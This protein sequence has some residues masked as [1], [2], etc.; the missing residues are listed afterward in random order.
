M[1]DPATLIVALS[2]IHSH[3]LTHRTQTQ[4]RNGD[5][6]RELCQWISLCGFSQI[7]QITAFDARLR[8]DSQLCHPAQREA[9][10]SVNVETEGIDTKDLIETLVGPTQPKGRDDD[11]KDGIPKLDDCQMQ[12][13][14]AIGSKQSSEGLKQNV[15]D[16]LRVGSFSRKFLSLIAHES[17]TPFVVLALFCADGDNTR[18]ALQLADL[19]ASF[20]DLPIDR[21][22]AVSWKIPSS[23]RH[24]EGNPVDLYGQMFL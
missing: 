21:S 10:L 16:I 6:A 24:L 3:S 9:F 14:R 22:A 7:T 4:N 5:F 13:L 8:V 1:I 20:F 2:P 19:A 12:I 15:C 23:W 17:T 18:D 11:G